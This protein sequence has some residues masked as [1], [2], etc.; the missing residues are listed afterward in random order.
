MSLD[1]FK[2]A[3]SRTDLDCVKDEDVDV[4]RVDRVVGS[5]DEG[6][7]DALAQQALELVVLHIDGERARQG[8][9]AFALHTLPLLASQLAD[10]AHGVACRSH[11]WTTEPIAQDGK[12][13][14]SS[15]LMRTLN[16]RHSDGVHSELVLSADT[17]RSGDRTAQH[18]R[19]IRKSASIACARSTSNFL[20]EDE[21][22]GVLEEDD[23]LLLELRHPL[24][25]QAGLVQQSVHVACKSSMV[26]RC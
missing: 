12:A 20:P 7:L 9:V 1:G 10:R 13:R 2:P 15:G 14:C 24:V 21:T 8:L 23:P 18:T 26:C 17:Q 16:A 3:E 6:L 11:R 19:Q 25:H 22:V 4:A 5:L